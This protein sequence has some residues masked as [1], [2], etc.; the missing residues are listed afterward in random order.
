MEEPL[1]ARGRPAEVV[2]AEAVAALLSHRASGAAFEAHLGDQILPL[3]A[4][5]DGS[6]IFTVDRV[7][8]HL[9]T[10]AWVLDR[11]GLARIDVREVVGGP[12]TVAV[13]PRRPDD[14]AVRLLALD[15]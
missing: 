15:G 9:L 8:R 4:L 10:N 3:L 11:F 6:S 7:S 5:A 13:S 12:P 14:D 1:G 2:A